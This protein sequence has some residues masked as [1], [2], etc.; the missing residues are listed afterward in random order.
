MAN[1][2]NC[3]NLS[4]GFFLRKIRADWSVLGVHQPSVP[5][6]FTVPIVRHSLEVEGVGKS[7]EMCGPKMGLG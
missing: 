5:L 1:C 7:V 3:T 4:L 2:T 6:R